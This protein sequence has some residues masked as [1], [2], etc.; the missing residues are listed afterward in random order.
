MTD[1][2]MT[3]TKYRALVF[4]HSHVWSIKRAIASGI[5][6]P[7][8]PDYDCDVVLCGTKE[9]PGP[10]VATGLNGHT[11]INACL[12]AAV[13][14][15]ENSNTTWLV[16][17]VQGNYYNIVGLTEP[18]PL[19]DFTLPWK[20][21]LPVQKSAR[22]LPYAAVAGFLQGHT[23]ELQLLL[24]QLP[25]LGFPNIIHVNAPPPIESES[26]ILE[27]LKAT[28]AVDAGEK[29]TRVTPALI[30]LKLWE[31]QAKMVEDICRAHGVHCIQ[32]PPETR[33]E[34]GFLKRDF[35]K[36]SVHAN[37]DYSALILEQIE[38]LICSKRD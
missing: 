32:P 19:F 16:S 21:D 5:Y 18:D 35:W 4:G 25:N 33:D 22:F 31:A 27:D 11:A 23:T 3:A 36:D 34:K 9:F 17:A 30:R 15:Y 26:F 37:E 10:L 12:I 38:T 13:Q 7:T 24:K 1:D 2:A 14:K 8:T 29:Q 28:G 20:T 6:R